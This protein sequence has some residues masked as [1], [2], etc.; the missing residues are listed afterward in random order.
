LA[1]GRPAAGVHDPA[2][3]GTAP[4]AMDER[5]LRA[6]AKL[7]AA[8]VENRGQTDSRVRYYAQGAGHAFYATS[9]EVVIAMER[10]AAPQALALKLQFVNRNPAAAVEGAAR[11]AGEVNYLHGADP[12][13]WRTGLPRYREIVYRDLWRGI[14]LRLRE[15]TG[16]LK[17]EFRVRPG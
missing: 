14:D 15:E 17:Y 4:A 2:A 5:L 8:F 11:D 9:D 7:P 12:G 3:A 1:A 10:G 6:Y 16:V 13:G